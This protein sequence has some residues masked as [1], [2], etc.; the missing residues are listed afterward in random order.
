MISQMTH[1]IN[2]IDRSERKIKIEIDGVYHLFLY[3]RDFKKQRLNM[4]EEGYELSDDELSVLDKH[5]IER[6]KKRIMFLLGRQDYPK[7]QLQDKLLREGYIIEHVDEIL[8]PFLEKAIINDA[9]LIS[10]RI[11]GYKTYKSRLEIQMNLQKKG[12][13]KDDVKALIQENMT[14]EDELASATHLLNKKFFLKQ[15]KMDEMTLKQKALGFLSR[16]GYSMD[17][18]IKAYESFYETISKT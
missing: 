5:V 4:L 1:Q 17:I 10:R 8:Q 13:A 2:K 18:C 12:F 15:F 7:K 6:G 9:Q 3:S 11:S 14:W 16:K